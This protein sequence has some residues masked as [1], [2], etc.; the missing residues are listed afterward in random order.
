MPHT[1]YNT[2]KWKSYNKYKIGTIAK[3]ECL[4]SKIYKININ[5]C[6]KKCEYIYI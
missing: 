6:A 4:I 3:L 2:T 1:K 5:Q